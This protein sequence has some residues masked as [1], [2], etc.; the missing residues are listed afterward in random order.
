MIDNKWVYEK[1]TKRLE[2]N[3]D[4]V[5]D[6]MVNYQLTVSHKMHFLGSVKFTLEN[7]Q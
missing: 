3:M 2:K 5:N 6:N 7:K 1:E 4:L